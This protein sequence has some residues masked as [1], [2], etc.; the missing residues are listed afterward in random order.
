LPAQGL[1]ADVDEPTQPEGD[2]LDHGPLEP[3][4]HGVVQRRPDQLDADR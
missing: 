1:V 2:V 4:D 3:D